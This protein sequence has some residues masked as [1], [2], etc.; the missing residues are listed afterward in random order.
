M[1]SNIGVGLVLFLIAIG[2]I[3]AVIAGVRN[4]IDGRSDLKRVGMMG[5]P[6]AIFVISY[7]SFGSI[8]QAG[9]ATMIAMLG[10]MAL[11]IIISSTRRTFNL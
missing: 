8:D 4:V 3:A 1:F 10:L 2:F 6:V 5:V 11:G 9:I 7:F